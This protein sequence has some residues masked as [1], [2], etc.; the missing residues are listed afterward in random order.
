M[1]KAKIIMKSKYIKKSLFI[2]V[3]EGCRGRDRMVVLLITPSFPR[4]SSEFFCLT[5]LQQYFSYVV[6]VSFIGGRNQSTP[7]NLR[8]VEN[9]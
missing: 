2:S 5:P 4:H 7:K 3:V 9:H 8:P 1:F 6:A